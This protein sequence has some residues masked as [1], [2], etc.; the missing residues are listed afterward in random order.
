[1][2]NVLKRHRVLLLSGALGL[3][4]ALFSGMTVSSYVRT[5]PVVVAARDIEPRQKIDRSCVKVVHVPARAVHPRALG[6]EEILGGF[7]SGY[8]VAGQQILDGHVWRGIDEAGL[9]VELPAGWRAMFVPLT[10]QRCLGGDVKPGERT[11]IIF[12]PREEFPGLAARAV[13][14]LRDVPVLAVKTS[15]EGDLLGIVVRAAPQA[16]ETLA[17]CLERGSVYACLVPAAEATEESESG[18]SDR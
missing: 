10:S 8:L 3:S 17:T 7:A 6:V 9:S 5:S 14:V 4:A 2:K 16:C 1:M 18:V 12:C 15:E 13:T 11:D